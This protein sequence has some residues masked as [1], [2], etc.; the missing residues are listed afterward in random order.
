MS[1]SELGIQL[2]VSAEIRPTLKW[3]FRMIH[4]YYIVHYYAP[5][6]LAATSD[7]AFI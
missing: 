3:P 1:R 7:N 6:A 4:T 2:R 5:T